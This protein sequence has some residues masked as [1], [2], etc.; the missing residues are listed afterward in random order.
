VCVQA[1]ELAGLRGSGT[2]YLLS[3]S[4]TNLMQAV[5]FGANFLLYCGC[6]VGRGANNGNSGSGSIV[7][8]RLLRGR[9]RGKASGGASYQ[10]RG[11]RA[12]TSSRLTTA[13]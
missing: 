12:V 6:A 2:G 5:W 8:T 4:I 7:G 10:L 9:G 3:V 13:M 1:A 11:A